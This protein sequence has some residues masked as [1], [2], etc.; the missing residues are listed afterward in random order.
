MPGI[1]LQKFEGE[2][3]NFILNTLINF[4]P[5]KR[6]INFIWLREIYVQCCR[7]TSIVLRVKCSPLLVLNASQVKIKAVAMLDVRIVE[8]L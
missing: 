1:S 2:I 4:K 6:F 8:F 7:S 3:E 5:V